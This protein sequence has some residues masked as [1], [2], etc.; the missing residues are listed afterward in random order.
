VSAARSHGLHSKDGVPSYPR[1]RQIPGPGPE[2]LPDGVRYSAEMSDSIDTLTPRQHAAIAALLTERTHAQAAVKA[3]IAEQTLRRWLATDQ[4]F[5]TAYRAARRAVIDGMIGRL[6]HA[7]GAAVDALER[8]LTCGKPADE[9]RAAVAVLDHAA[10][11][12]ELGDLMERVEELERLLEKGEIDATP[13][14][15]GQVAGA[16]PG[17]PN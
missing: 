12:L 1:S 3:K 14:T 7:A 2:S 4:T 6:Q 11:G 15:A 17:S 13:P 9:I 16:G 5:V 10:R 8:N